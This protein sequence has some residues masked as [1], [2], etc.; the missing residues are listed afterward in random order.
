MLAPWRYRSSFFD[1]NDRG[2]SPCK[3]YIRVGIRKVV[4]EIVANFFAIVM[5][6]RTPMHIA[7]VSWDCAVAT[8]GIILIHSVAS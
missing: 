1:M 6:T 4:V 8:A 3:W 2:G 5:G 7:T